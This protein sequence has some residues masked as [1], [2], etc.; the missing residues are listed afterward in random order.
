MIRA[1]SKGYGSYLLLM[2]AVAW[3]TLT[4]TVAR[5]LIYVA[6]ILAF[7]SSFVSEEKTIFVN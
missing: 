7:M 3:K 4:A 5:L 6:D 1:I 2:L